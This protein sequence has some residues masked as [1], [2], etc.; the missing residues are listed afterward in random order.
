M[1]E[2]RLPDS[3]R[4]GRRRRLFTGTAGAALVTGALWLQSQQ[5]GYLIAGLAATIA[6]GILLSMLRAD[7]RWRGGVVTA[8]LGLFYLTAARGQVELARLSRDWPAARREVVRVGA[9]AL[10]AK[11]AE[12]ATT[13]AASAARAL[14][15]PPSAPSI[16]GAATGAVHLRGTTP[17]S[18]S[19][20]L[21]ISP[22]SLVAPLGVVFTPSYVV[23]YATA[24]RGAERG[25]ATAV[26]HADAPADRLAQPI[27]AEIA[28]AS[29]LDGFEMLVPV[30]VPRDSATTRFAPNG[31]PLVA[32][33][34]LAEERG[35][36]TLARVT[37]H[38]RA[39]TLVLALALLATIAVAWQRERHALWRLLPLG[40]AIVLLD[41]LPLTA[42]S[43][44]SFLF[45]PAVYF[46]DLPYV[47]DAL[48]ASVG[49]LMLAS[50]TVLIGLLMLLRA[51]LS[52]PARWVA[53][54]VAL[55]LMAA[56]P[57]ML[58]DLSRG[59][60]PPPAGAAPALWVAWEV[61]LFLAASAILVGAAAAG[62]AAL[63][64]RRG[65][66]PW[67]APAVAAVAALLG[68][69]ALDAPGQWPDWYPAL[70]IA[71]IGALALTPRT[72]AM[73]LAAATCAAL[74]ATTLTWNADVRG[75]V[76]LANRDLAG[77]S[78]VD[79]SVVDGLRRFGRSIAAGDALE[80]ASD[81]L[82]AYD[83]SD[84]VNTGYPVSLTAWGPDGLR[85]ATLTSA[86]FEA[87]EVLDALVM[88]TQASGV[89]DVTSLPG[90]PGTFTVLTVPHR[91]GGVTS[92]TV[93]PRTRL[94]P[95]DPFLPLLG[96]ERRDRGEPPYGISLIDVGAARAIDSTTT[97]WEREGTTLHGDRLVRTSRGVERAHIEVELR[98]LYTLLQR[99]TLIVLLD[100]V[101]LFGLWVLSVVPDGALGR[102]TRWQ[103]RRWAQSYRAR[104]TL[105]LFGFF[106]IPA[107]AFATWG[108]QR[109]QAEDRQS[110]EL[111]VT[112]TLR[113]AAVSAQVNEL[114][115]LG[116][117]LGTP[118]FVY[119]DGEL[120]ATSEPLYSTLAPVG[121]FLP[122]DVFRTLD[123]LGREVTASHSERTGGTPTLFGYVA[124]KT[125]AGDRVVIAAPARG[126]DEALDLRR[127][128]LGVLLLFSSVVG[129]I[130][131]LW[132]SG[133]AARSLAEP[134][135]R[136]RQAALA[137]AGGEREPPLA[138]APPVEFV[139]V[140]TAFRRMA[141]DLGESRTAL[142]A[143]Q[144]RTAAVLRNVASGVVAVDRD[145]RVTLANPRA[146]SLLQQSS[147]EA[148]TRADEALPSALAARVRDFLDGAD[149]EREFELSL[150]GRQV[151]A[152]LT[153]LSTGAGGAV[154]TLDDVTD[155]ARAQRVL[156]WGEMARQVA[157]E[158]KNPLTPI[159]LGVQHLQR[160][161]ADARP[162]FD[163]I[164][165]RNV[166]RILAEIDRLDEI[167]RSFSRYGS[168]PADRA[169]AERV[170]VASIASDVVD[171]EKLGRDDVEWCTQGADTPAP[172]DARADELREVLLNVLENA[173]HAGARR[174]EV[175]VARNE[176]HVVLEV[177]DDG[178][179]IPA[180]ILPRI[181]EPHFST[182]TSGSGLGLAI[183]RQ[184]VESWGGT[185]A[186]VSDADA[187]TG[188]A[189][190]ITL[191]ASQ[192]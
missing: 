3:G 80:T 166:E 36:A 66:P 1:V 73:T 115:G 157:H 15:S 74:G 103:T 57:F 20:R 187:G 68:P 169:P 162:D 67:F 183:S 43:G 112:Q 40:I 121:R 104:L 138:G 113:A 97:R 18:W 70:W 177:T 31:V 90:D 170:D 163:Q 133:L 167:A 52:V 4:M 190:R 146:A 153:R 132:L 58:R 149:E 54:A 123:V 72:R 152:R 164:L 144:R 78:V 154:M 47:G 147:L 92:V 139:P 38:Q 181:F 128:D 117:R 75:R 160:A 168:A 111:L 22:D 159:R 191:Q 171:L 39:G 140:F 94:V 95:D 53:V 83:H 61:A 45:N 23:M 13:L 185:I 42:F 126:N 101:V 100:L 96:L 29:R 178:R 51:R 89:V 32:F 87:P 93:G 69:V 129:A 10:A 141:A 14:D 176:G 107:T 28:R 156:A 88:R 135:G 35:A 119:H 127:R 114:A 41:L 12:V 26:L 110:R 109:L 85:E 59:V 71:A 5:V 19:G 122:A 9:A 175:S 24:S 44:S 64:G 136:L 105:V 184:L 60:T 76:A 108:Y 27:D 116:R 145:G 182:S 125:P 82:K 179:G 102:W 143:A 172:A 77:L 192:R 142:E 131:A 106:V 48:T 62:A 173:R 165:E 11:L 155:L 6:T 17:Q 120:R 150:V 84:L 56:G 98:S 91:D 186:I 25:V 79:S 99:G 151:Q 46:A 33:R 130:L 65:L 63:G 81:L 137:I 158:I 174:V 2:D 16:A 8:F 21:V 118:L 50:G 30:R 55:A 161:R 86:P 124:A 34:A 180:S 134:I 49:A 189:V 37:W 7:A 148:G 188:T